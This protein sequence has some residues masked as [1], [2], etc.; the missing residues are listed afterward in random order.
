MLHL[1]SV[2]ATQAGLSL[3]QVAV[4]GKSNEIAAIPRLLELLD[5][6]GALVTIAAIGC[7]KEIAR[8]I[9]SQGGDYALTVK[10]N[11]PNLAADILSSSFTGAQEVD[12]RG[13]GTTCTRPPRAGTAGWRGGRTRGDVRAGQDPGPRRVG[14]ADGDPAVPQRADGRGRDLERAA[15]V[16]RQPPCR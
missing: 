15:A 12:T 9:V 1:V 8:Q 2:W 10:D 6:K 3:G 7:Q 11:Q 13:S 16:H 4:E 5:L 14:E